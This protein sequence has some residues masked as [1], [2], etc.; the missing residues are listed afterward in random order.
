MSIAQA[1]IDIA[2]EDGF[3]AVSMRNVAQRLGVGTMSLY[4]YVRTKHELLSVMGDAIMAEALIPDGEVPDG[5]REGLAEIARRT[6]GIFVGHPWILASWGQAGRGD[7]G[8]SV[9]HHIEQ[10]MAIVAELDFLTI[11]ERLR[12]TGLVDEFVV[13]HVMRNASVAAPG[14]PEDTWQAFI[15]E[16][17][18]TGE[19]PHL[20]EMFAAELGDPDFG[21]FDTSLEIVLD[22]IAAFIAGRG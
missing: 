14:A 16:Q 1:A 22:G 4:H 20:S 2:D 17:A 12:V 8:L 7:P 11:P 21:D 6:R 3:E 19:Y 18:A 5:W 9:V 10:T 13:G 15:A